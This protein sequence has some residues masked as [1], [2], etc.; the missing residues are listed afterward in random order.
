MPRAASSKQQ[1]AK[2]KQQR[3]SSREQRGC[4]EC[5]T[6]TSNLVS[7]PSR[8]ASQKIEA[9]AVTRAAEAKERRGGEA[10]GGLRQVGR[11]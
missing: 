4:N 3:A 5:A 6:R 8:A 7:A 11:A 2:S 9:A 1:A 10:A